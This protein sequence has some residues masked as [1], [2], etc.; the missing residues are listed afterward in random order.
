MC[1]ERKYSQYDDRSRACYHRSV[2]DQELK[3]WQVRWG[4]AGRAIFRLATVSSK[5]IG[6]LCLVAAVGY[7]VLYL[8]S[9]WL[10]SKQ[11]GKVDPRLSMAPLSLPAKAE[12]PLSD[13]S[14]D[15]YGFK[16]Q[17]PNKEIVK[18]I[19]GE[20]ITLVLFR[21]G[22]DLIVRN[23]SRDAGIFALLTNDKR[24]QRLLGQDVNHSE[25]KLI[26]A[27]MSATPEQAKW[28]R[29][30]SSENERVEYL[31]GMKLSALTQSASPHAFTLGPIYSIAYGKFRGFHLGNPDVPP[32]ETHLDLF[33][34]A[35]RYFA[36]DITGPEGHGQVLT[37]EEIN[38]IVDSIRP[39][40]DH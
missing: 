14:I 37:Q 29:F 21:D 32:Y 23:T 9:P 16:F 38:A 8:I 17:L 15:R 40:S 24:A 1:G 6:L 5:I 26:Q 10:A 33:D 36:F 31:L 25:F 7:G 28:W 20:L 18:T 35:D 34:G 39:T 12:A 2:K 30:R 22:G 3:W 27:V 4:L 13:A 19:G 11:L